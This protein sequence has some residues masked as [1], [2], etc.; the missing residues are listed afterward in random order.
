[1]G[2]VRKLSTLDHGSHCILLERDRVFQLK[3]K[4]EQNPMCVSVVHHLLEL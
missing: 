4:D 1:M 2:I 3:G